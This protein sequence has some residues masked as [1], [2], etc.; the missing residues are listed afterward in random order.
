M[1]S[2]QDQINELLRK[3][4]MLLKK[5]ADFS[6]DVND[7]QRELIQL[8]KS[9]LNISAIEKPVEKEFIEFQPAPIQQIIPQTH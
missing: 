8:K 1:T 5:Q 2:N 9:D 6:K 7:L 4:E 3:L